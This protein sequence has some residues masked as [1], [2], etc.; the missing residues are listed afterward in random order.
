VSLGPTAPPD[1]AWPLTLPEVARR[2]V[3]DVAPD[4]LELLPATTQA[5]L[6]GTEGGRWWR[7]LAGSIGFGAGPELVSQLV[8]PILAGGLAQVVGTAL[9]GWRPQHLLQRLRRRRRDPE[10]P[11]L[12]P[13][14]IEAV[15][16]ACLDRARAAG[17]GKGRSELLADSVY[18]ALTRQ[19]PG[20]DP[21]PD[22]TR[23]PPED[24]DPDPDAGR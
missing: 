9:V 8:Y 7:A 15:R 13:E 1:P 20:A 23:N 5:W 2:V 14:Q 19:P 6:S 16:R 10:V 18:A 17:L 21:R 22:L 11:P 12:T 3:T 4:E 24:E